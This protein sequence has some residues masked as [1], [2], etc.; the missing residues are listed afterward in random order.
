LL[1][2]SKVASGGELARAMLAL[3]FGAHRRADRGPGRGQRRGN[4]D[5]WLSCSTRSTQ[6]LV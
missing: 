5:L 6:A 3:A 2:L 1:P 4:K